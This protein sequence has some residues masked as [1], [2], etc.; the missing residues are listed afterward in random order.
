MSKSTPDGL[1]DQQALDNIRALQR[2][3]SRVFEKVVGIYLK[4]CPA[5]IAELE[6]ALHAGDA[7]R[8]AQ[9]AHRLKS[10]SA[11]LGATALA[12]YL[13]ELEAIG[14]AGSCEGA[15]ELISLVKDEYGRVE[16]ALRQELQIAHAHQSE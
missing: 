6:S 8:I 12:E 4:D 9:L 3:G 1:L 16:A 13:R 14:R 10:G 2:P 5:A 11:N 15:A 7:T